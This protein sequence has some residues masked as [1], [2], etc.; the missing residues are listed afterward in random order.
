MCSYHLPLSRRPRCSCANARRV[1]RTKR[2]VRPRMNF[3]LGIRKEKEKRNVEKRSLSKRKKDGKQDKERKKDPLGFLRR[4][5]NESGFERRAFSKNRK[6]RGKSRPKSTVCRLHA[7]HCHPR[8]VL[9]DG[10]GPTFS[11]RRRESSGIKGR[12]LPANFH[13]F[14]LARIPSSSRFRR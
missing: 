10:R 6:I 8:R 12:R 13:D 4:Q 1:Q 11:D 3:W 7:R 2:R 14:L 5:I 9:V